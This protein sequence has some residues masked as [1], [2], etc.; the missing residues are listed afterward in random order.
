MNALDSM[1]DTNAKLNRIE[2]MLVSIK[3]F[4]TEGL[5]EAQALRDELGSGA[6]G[7]SERLV[8]PGQ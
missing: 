2:A 7:T 4:T 6:L 3:D 1:A 8:Q 5:A